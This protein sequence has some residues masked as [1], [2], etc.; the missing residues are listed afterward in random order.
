[1][2]GLPPLLGFIGKELIYEAKVQ[3]PGLGF[4]ILI[5]GVISNIF[6]VSVSLLFLSKVFLG[7][8]KTYIK[9]PGLNHGL[10]LIGPLVLAMFS[11]GFGLFPNLLSSI[12]EP[13][14]N[15]IHAEE[16]QIKLKLW[17]GFN[18]VLLLSIFTVAIGVVLFFF[19]NR[20]NKLLCKWRMLN[21][22]IISIRLTDVFTNSIDGFIAFSSKYTKYIQHGYHRYYLLT[23][24]AFTSVLLWIQV[25]FTRG[26]ELVSEFTLNPLY[27]SGLVIVIA[28][29]AVFSAVSKSRIST[30]VSMGVTGYGISLIYM[31]YSSVDLAITQVIVETLIV[32]MFVLVLQKL[33]RFATLSKRI[34]RMR[35]AIIALS[36][37]AVMTVLALKSINVDFNNSISGFFMENS[38]AKAF[39]KN[40]VNVILVDFRALDTLGEVTVLTIAA[41]GVFTLLNFK[42]QKK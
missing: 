28:I 3:S 1:M 10:F 15:A 22:R 14:L 21:S 41:I 37:G 24:I 39:G 12:I 27:I 38:V 4:L 13:A 30:I 42:T 16:I 34:S 25:F 5:L 7:K 33:P 36:F 2:A 40:V 6:M 35:D 9:Q 23:I 17:H 18:Q 8:P 26:W 29:S 31:Y 19:I 32:V 20:N 11:L